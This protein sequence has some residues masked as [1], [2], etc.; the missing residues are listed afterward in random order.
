VQ[1]EAEQVA[2]R[3]TQMADSLKSYRSR[4][5]KF[6]KAMQSWTEDEV[7]CSEEDPYEGG[8]FASTGLFSHGVAPFQ[9][10]T[11]RLPVP[12]FKR[13]YGNIQINYLGISGFFG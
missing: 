12:Y 11:L 10:A 2:Q 4:Y 7:K 1:A 13:V 3:T 5:P 9:P 8:R 6:E